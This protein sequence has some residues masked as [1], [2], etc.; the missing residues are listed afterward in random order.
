[1]GDEEQRRKAVSAVLDNGMTQ[2][3]VSKQ[4]GITLHRLR[5]WL[6]EERARRAHLAD[7]ERYRARE[8]TEARL[9]RLTAEWAQH[10]VQPGQISEGLKKAAKVHVFFDYIIG[11]P[12]LVIAAILGLLLS[13]FSVLIILDFFKLA[14]NGWYAAAMSL[15]AG[16]AD[17]LLV[18][19]IWS[20][21]QYFKGLIFRSFAPFSYAVFNLQQA[22]LLLEKRQEALFA[23]PSS[24]QDKIDRHTITKGIGRAVHVLDATRVGA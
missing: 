3:S 9:Q 16:L 17:L 19:S 12:I 20:L 11:G 7:V 10:E 18:V 23:A 13:L 14:M 6:A 22:W 2:V 4:H 15:F 1:M 5:V 8:S 21:A 24:E